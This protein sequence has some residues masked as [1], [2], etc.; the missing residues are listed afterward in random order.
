MS[1]KTLMA[2]ALVTSLTGLAGAV[3]G[4][5]KKLK[6]LKKAEEALFH[7]ATENQDLVKQIEELTAVVAS[8]SAQA[9]AVA[10]VVKPARKAPAKK[11]APKTTN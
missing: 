3:T 8:L 4:F 11:A 1:D 10:E 7:S 9:Q 6:T 2:T 5:L